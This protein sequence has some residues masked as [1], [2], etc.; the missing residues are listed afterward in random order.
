[1]KQGLSNLQINK[2]EEKEETKGSVH[3]LAPNGMDEHYEAYGVVFKLRFENNGLRIEVDINIRSP[4]DQS[5]PQELPV[6]N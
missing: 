4:I 5:I 1:M 2:E 3:T 6:S